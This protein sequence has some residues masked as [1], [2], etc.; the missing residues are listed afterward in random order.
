VALA[1]NDATGTGRAAVI[2][3]VTATQTYVG[4]TATNGNV[5]WNNKDS[6]TALTN[7]TTITVTKG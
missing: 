2:T 1:Q 6:V 7:S 3:A 5:A 4:A